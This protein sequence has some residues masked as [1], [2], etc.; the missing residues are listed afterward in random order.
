MAVPGVVIGVS[1][2]GV[3]TRV[4]LRRKLSS[5]SGVAIL[6]PS[7]GVPAPCS[8]GEV[9]LVLW[10]LFPLFIMRRILAVVACSE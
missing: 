10:L 7:K 8:F 2:T 5:G 6:E 4:I 3:S 1:A 9:T